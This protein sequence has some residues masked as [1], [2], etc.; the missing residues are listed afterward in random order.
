MRQIRNIFDVVI[1]LVGSFGC[2]GGYS[3]IDAFQYAQFSEIFGTF[4]PMRLNFRLEL[5]LEVTLA[6]MDFFFVL[7]STLPPIFD[8]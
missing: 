3:R 4:F 1:D 8:E 2:L 5:N 7:P 6:L